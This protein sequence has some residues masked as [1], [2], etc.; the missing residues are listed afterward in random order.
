[1][2][3]GWLIPG[4]RSFTFLGVASESVVAG[5]ESFIDARLEALPAEA[6]DIVEPLSS[7][8]VGVGVAPQR[9]KTQPPTLA[10]SDGL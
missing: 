6:P 4:G 3:P 2:G 1:M 9:P 10:P 8:L 7:L 5:F